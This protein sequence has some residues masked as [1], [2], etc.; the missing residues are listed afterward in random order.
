MHPRVKGIQVCS[1]EGP[2]ISSRGGDYE[3]PKYTWRN[4]KNHWVNF[5]PH[6]VDNDLF[7][8]LDQHY[9]NSMCLLIWNVFSGE[10]C[11]QCASSF[12]NEIM[13]FVVLA[14]SFVKCSSKLQ[15]FWFYSNEDVS[16]S[17]CYLNDSLNTAY[18]FSADLTSLCSLMKDPVMI[19]FSVLVMQ[20]RSSGLDHNNWALM[21]KKVRNEYGSSLLKE[22]KHRTISQPFTS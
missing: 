12:K 10:Q 22:A 5:I 19:Y 14:W 6:K 15:L 20:G 17:N 21:S 18:L 8:S 9:Y 2:C 3:I 4:S 16:S 13:T 7:S 11:G 1:N